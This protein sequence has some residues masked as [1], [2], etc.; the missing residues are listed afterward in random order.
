LVWA[1]SFEPLPPADFTFTNGAEIK[2]VD[3]AI[4]TGQPEGR[5]IS[6]IFEGLC[7]WD[8]KTLE[9]TPGVAESWD[10]SD[11]KLTYTFHLRTDAVWSDG[12]SVT[13]EDFVWSYRRFLHPETSSEYAY[14]MWYIVGAKE[15]NSGKVEPGDPVEIELREKP[16]G[17]RPFASGVLLR[18]KLLAVEAADDP[19]AQGLHP[20][21]VAAGN[22]IHI[23]EINGHK[24]RFQQ[25]AAAPDTEDYAWLIRDFRSVA[26]H[27]LD[28]Q[29]LRIR[30]K[31]PVPYF[32]NL[33]GFY[34]MS[35]V[36]RRCIETHG[37]PA[38][39]KPENIVSNGPFMLKFRRIRDR[40]RV[41]KSPTYWDRDNVHL[42]IIDALAVESATTALN[43]YMTGRT[44]WIPG[45]PPEIVPDLLKRRR[46]DFNP[47]PSL[48]NYYYVINTTRGPL[49]DVRVR[50]A[51]ALAVNK[52]E[53]VDTC[54]PAGEIPAWSSVPVEISKYIGY[55]PAECER[56][57]AEKARRLL[58]EAG[59]PD[60]RGFPKIEILYNTLEAHQAVAELI[61]SQ[62]KRE[63]GIDV[64]LQNQD[65]TRYLSSRREGKFDLAR[66]GWIGDYVDPNTFLEMFTGDN[67]TN[68]TGWSN[69]RFDR[70]LKQAKYERD[71][72][73]RMQ[74]FHD[75][76]RI[77]MDEMPII[78]IY[79]SVSRSMVRPY[80]KGYY[81]NIQDVHP[82]KSISIDW[83]MKRRLF[84]EEGLR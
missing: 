26:I 53:I 47:R 17:A 13:A 38:W 12:T 19:Q 82:L 39:T 41:V 5:V 70:L 23:I 69:P 15:F 44:D 6:A 57:N 80:V 64:R 31:H 10:I 79:F 3:P 81:P 1:V 55:V 74:L 16:P 52:R 24:Q 36:N 66:A 61:Q 58:A 78:P 48:S 51:L 45:V 50:R 20:L 14:E 63:L 2:T 35:P 29:T 56:R 68:Q 37:Y 40:V 62:W 83:D 9:P 59:F 25:D 30:L 43:L 7:H 60:G 22:A 75:A 84:K 4:V 42:R 49:R 67:P 54:A 73:R 65:W 18:G 28:R 72:A 46:A 33:M 34:P 32:A 8:P 21:G 27:A 11:D 76:E 71:D 77:L